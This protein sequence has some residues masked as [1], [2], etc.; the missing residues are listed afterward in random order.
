ML[1]PTMRNGNYFLLSMQNIF[2]CFFKKIFA[3][4]RLN[5]K[6]NYEKISVN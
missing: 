6:V 3:F 1:N 2:L 5:Q 4:N